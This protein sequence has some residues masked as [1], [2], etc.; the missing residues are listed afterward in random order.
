MNLTRKMMR[1]H[2]GQ[3]ND[4]KD[5]EG[6]IH[7]IGLFNI[8]SMRPLQDPCRDGEWVA[9]PKLHGIQHTRT[10]LSDLCYKK[11]QSLNASTSTATTTWPT[12]TRTRM[13]PN[14]GDPYAVD[15][16]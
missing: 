8:K 2:Q 6:D 13:A 7:N 12:A 16:I 4:F 9:L 1:T 10:D 15:V 5:C 3:Q 14:V 11:R